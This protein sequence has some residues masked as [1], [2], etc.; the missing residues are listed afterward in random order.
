MPIT[1][2]ICDDN[3]T[4]LSG[5]RRLLNI[6]SENKDFVLNIDE[7]ISAESFLFSYPDKPCDLL[8]LDIEMKE[9]NGMELAK[10]LRSRGDMLP[11]IFITGYSEY[12]NE[13]YEVEALHYLLK[14]VDQEKLFK[15]LD[16]YVKHR[17][18]KKEILLQCE[19]EALH[20]SADEILYLEANGKKTSV[21]LTD[22][23]QLSCTAGI[24]TL[25]NTLPEDFALCHRSFIVNI[26]YIRSIGREELALDN[27]DRLPVSRRMYKEVNEK[28]IKYFTNAT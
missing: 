1:A 2:A 21:K 26:R 25:K 23:K 11:I 12:M 3:E 15:V 9:I 16:R 17:S 18:M 22:G 6:W 13:G 4:Q 8:L 19:D 5:L 10:K 7:Y 28:F 14:P 20:V 27:G 24:N